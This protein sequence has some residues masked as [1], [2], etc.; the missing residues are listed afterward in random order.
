MLTQQL[1][2]GSLALEPPTRERRACVLL[3]PE[4][5]SLRMLLL[6]LRMLLRLSSVMGP[7]W[8]A[9]AGR[10]VLIPRSRRARG[11]QS[12]SPWAGATFAWL[13]RGLRRCESS[14][15]P[16]GGWLG[17]LPAERQDKSALLRRGF[18]A[19]MTMPWRMLT[20]DVVDRKSRQRLKLVY[21]VGNDD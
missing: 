21:G 5:D 18:V 2:L 19:A 7:R 20:T 10:T 15:N 12:S 14:P 6:W 13:R 8:E 3:E 4:R 1:G 16:S 9:R 11:V 17:L